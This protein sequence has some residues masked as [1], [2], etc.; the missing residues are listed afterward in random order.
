MNTLKNGDFFHMSLYP[1]ITVPDETDLPEQ[2]GTKEKY[3]FWVDD[4]HYLFKLGRVN[5]GENWAEKVSCELCGLLELPHAD[6]NFGI[7]KGQKGIISPTIV[8]PGGRLILGNEQL[9]KAYEDY[10]AQELRGVRQ[11]TVN[12]VAALLMKTN[13]LPPLSWGDSEYIKTALD[14]FVG[15]LLLDAWI[16]NSDRHH[17]NWGVILTDSEKIHLAPTFDHASSLGCHETDAKRVARLT[18]LDSGFHVSS[19]VAKARSALYL[20]SK[21][22]KSLTTLDAF[23]HLAKKRK[24]AALAWLNRLENTMLDDYRYIFSRIPD[25]HI[26]EASSEFALKILE[27]NKARLLAL[28]NEL[29]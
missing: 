23:K 22:P 1:I 15:Y 19:Y 9:E 28:K 26:S 16:G 14:V 18:T 3:W 4:T 27:L 12:R 7:W 6:Y 24:R 20:C 21:S 8:P 29:K 10:P 17:E 13:V 11:H 5:T 2:L 25:D